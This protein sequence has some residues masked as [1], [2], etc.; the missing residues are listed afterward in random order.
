MV[1]TAG[2][3]PFR[4]GSARPV[5]T[6]SDRTVRDGRLAIVSGSDAEAQCTE[7]SRAARASQPRCP[8]SMPHPVVDEHAV[9]TRA[10]HKRCDAAV[11]PSVDDDLG[12]GT[13]VDFV[14][15]ERTT[16]DSGTRHRQILIRARRR[17]GERYLGTGELRAPLMRRRLRFGRRQTSK[18]WPIIEVFRTVPM[19]AIVDART[20][21]A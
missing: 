16:P 8:R 3:L 1:L 4:I 12:V 20:R 17:L 18:G 11:D 5:C 6:Y 10:A 14:T 15:I 19:N 9:V 7:P 2:S 13:S 21:S